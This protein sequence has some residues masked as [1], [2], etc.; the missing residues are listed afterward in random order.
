HYFHTGCRA[1][2]EAHEAK[3]VYHAGAAALSVEVGDPH[4]PLLEKAGWS[5]YLG[6]R[7]NLRRSLAPRSHARSDFAKKAGQEQGH[8]P[9]QKVQI[10]LIDLIARH[11]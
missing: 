9:A 6:S 5:V 10:K 7:R 8:Y 4:P 1:P 3:Q 2:I 11:D